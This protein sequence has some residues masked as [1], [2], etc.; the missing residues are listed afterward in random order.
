[1]T[2]PVLTRRLAA[3]RLAADNATADLNE[4]PK[5]EFHRQASITA[6]RGLLDGGF[7]KPTDLKFD[8]DLDPIRDTQ[9][10]QEILTEYA[11]SK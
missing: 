6:L 9:A 1:M 8:P 4:I 2:W 5:R 10:F 11:A 3:A 7:Y